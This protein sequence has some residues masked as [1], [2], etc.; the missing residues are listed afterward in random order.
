M[1]T[2]T[3]TQTKGRRREA[4]VE[5]SRKA[6]FEALC[7]QL[8][9][10]ARS[11]GP[12]KKLPTVSELCE[13]TRVSVKTLDRALSELETR[14][15]ILRRNGVGIFVSPDVDKRVIAL[16][17][18]PMIFGPGQVSTFWETL[19]QEVR[20]RAASDNQLL[21]LH[22]MSIVGNSMRL[23][24]N[25]VAD[26]RSR[27][28]DG[29]LMVGTYR[30]GARWIEDSRVA[31]VVFAGPGSHRVAI[32][33]AAIIDLGARAL[34]RRGCRRIALWGPESRV[35]D[36]EAANELRRSRIAAF[37]QALAAFGLPCAP[38]LIGADRVTVAPGPWIQASRSQE[39]GY[40]LGLECFRGPAERR[41]DG[42][43]IIDDVMAVGVFAAL[44]ELGFRPGADVQ[45]ASHTN[46]GS[47]TLAGWENNVIRLEID[48]KLLTKA[49]FKQLDRLMAGEPD[50]ESNVDIAPVEVAP[51]S[52]RKKTE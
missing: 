36:T 32:D 25:V 33:T 43:V 31:L 46:R 11:L 8:T 39:Q 22:F 20:E 14:R 5:A 3:A 40:R 37:E 34:A 45:I 29:V 15:L 38:E 18:D 24:S 9:G 19:L 52:E 26:I 42:I 21:D 16:I 51:A 27:R 28:I 50:V 35:I 6:S 4:H 1:T 12:G 30:D 17:C 49:M 41:P 7:T 2:V 48:P 13:K 10:F 47:A 23:P 44:Q